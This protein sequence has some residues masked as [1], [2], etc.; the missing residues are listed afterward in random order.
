MNKLQEIFAKEKK[1]IIG[2][3]HFPPLLG[4]KD[5]PG[6]GTA[7]KNA[8]QDLAAFQDGGVDAVIFENNYDIPHKTFVEPEVTGAMSFLMSKLSGDVRIPFGISM[9]WND[10]KAALSLSKVFGGKFIRVPVFVDSVE[11]DYGKIMAEPE[12]VIAFRKKIGAQHIALFTDIHVKHARMFENKTITESAQEAA[13]KGSG[14]VIITGNWTGNAPDISELKEAR[15]AVGKD[16]PILIGSGTDEKNIGEL[17]KYAN[18]AIISTALK[19]GIAKDG[20]VNVKG[21][22]Q[23]IDIEKVKRFMKVVG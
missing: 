12:K 9:L 21:Y 5:F 13:R 2:A 19:E 1:I 7:L 18:G 17:L 20:E 23:R 11:T 14:A 10:Y 4:Y 22:E 3:L 8:R 6:F 15:K 16:F